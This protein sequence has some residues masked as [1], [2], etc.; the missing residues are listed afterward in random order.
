MQK[1][2]G[3]I[4]FLLCFSNKMSQCVIQAIKK[5]CL[6]KV[7]FHN[8]DQLRVDSGE[9]SIDSGSVSPS[10][11]FSLNLP[12]VVFAKYCPH[13]LFYSK[14]LQKEVMSYPSG[15]VQAELQA[16]LVHRS[17]SQVSVVFSI[18][19]STPLSMRIPT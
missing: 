9:Y 1:H 12:C 10:K 6:K 2:T 7:L 4:G 13:R 3:V 15:N 16:A 11:Q 17:Q 18:R 8:R 5:T 14:V 19:K